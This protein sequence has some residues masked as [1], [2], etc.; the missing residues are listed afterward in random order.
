[1][2]DR[3]STDWEIQDANTTD[4]RLDVRVPADPL[5]AD[6]TTATDWGQDI[7]LPGTGGDISLGFVESV[8]GRGGH[9]VAEFGDYESALVSI[10]PPISTARPWGDVR[11]Y[12]TNLSTQVDDAITIANGAPSKAYVDAADATNAAAAATADAKAV[13]AATT[14]NNALPKSGGTMTGDIVLAADAN[15]PMEPVTKQQ[16]DAVSAAGVSKS[17]VDTAD[18]LLMPKAGGTFSGAVIHGYTSALKVPAG[19]QAQ[20]PTGVAGHIRYNSDTGGFEGFTS[21]WGAL[22][23]G[24][25]YVAPTP[26][27]APAQGSPWWNSEDGTL[28]TYYDDGN[29]QAW[30]PA[31]PMPAGSTAQTSDLLSA[32]DNLLIN[33]DFRIQ[34]RGISFSAQTSLFFT[35]DRWFVN[36]NGSTANASISAATVGVVN[37][38]VEHNWYNFNVTRTI[39]T[40]GV[41][42]NIGQRIEDVRT[43][44]GQTVTLSFMINSTIA[45]SA[46]FVSFDQTFGTGG[47]PSTQVQTQVLFTVSQVSVWE[48]KVITVAIPSISGKV[49]GTNNDHY[50]NVRVGVP[51]SVGNGT[52]IITNI[53]LRLGSLAPTKF[54]RRPLQQEVALCQRYCQ[55]FSG[56]VIDTYGAA[57]AAVDCCS[58]SFMTVMRA[59]PTSS[60]AVGPTYTNASNLVVASATGSAMRFKLTPTATGTATA[61]ADVLLDAEL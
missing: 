50:L 23:G 8:F 34:Q 61:F 55:R 2:I 15:A 14:A 54:L 24:A 53:D 10:A 25:F 40:G 42:L 29:S 36:P 41:E 30:V 43:A 57:G 7:R 56:L 28:Y 44:E 27:S 21:A 17:Y 58:V 35:A 46:M 20:R 60:Y 13:A 31:T 1:M 3:S 37:V 59:Q 45:T 11:L 38:G 19:T 48:R 4:W 32:E 52:W 12:L 6:P 39:T 9:V 26:P 5:P 18:A 49:L 16:L 22:G 47:S 51:T 33:G